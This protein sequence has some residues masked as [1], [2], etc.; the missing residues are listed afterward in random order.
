MPELVLTSK[1]TLQ[2]QAGPVPK[3]HDQFFSLLE[4][5]LK[6][7]SEKYQSLLE[8]EEDLK[9]ASEKYQPALLELEQIN[10]NNDP[11]RPNYVHKTNL[12]KSG[13]TRYNWVVMFTNAF[14]DIVFQGN[15][16]K[17]RKAHDTCIMSLVKQPGFK[18]KSDTNIQKGWNKFWEFCYKPDPE[19]TLFDIIHTAA[20]VYQENMVGCHD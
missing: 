7:A 2:P 1:N 6:P 20:D 8:S 9:P 5:N 17:L 16:E 18:E 12:P 4:E 19:A 11:N 14:D 3:H 13:L 10:T 15:R